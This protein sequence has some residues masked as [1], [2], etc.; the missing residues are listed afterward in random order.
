M[1]HYTPD[2]TDAAVRRFLARVGSEYVE[3]LFALRAA[4]SFAQEGKLTENRALDELRRRILEIENLD[5]AL[6]RDDLA[7]DGHE[8]AQIGIPRGPAMGVVID[9]LVET[10][11]DDPEQN[12]R[13]KLLEIARHYYETRIREK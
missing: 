12:S 4:D 7:V 1:F 13:E 10:V 6:S 5:H 11:L 3:N 2:W 9:H 8:L